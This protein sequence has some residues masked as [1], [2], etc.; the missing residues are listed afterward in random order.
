MM[1]PLLLAADKRKD[2]L[3]IDKEDGWKDWEAFA[4]GQQHHEVSAK[5]SFVVGKRGGLKGLLVVGRKGELR[6]WLLADR[7]D[8][9]VRDKED[10]VKGRLLAAGKK[11]RLLVVGMRDEDQ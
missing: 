5:D 2:L 8:L 1:D 7:K 11:N 3:V 10:G 6:G 4:R 9:L